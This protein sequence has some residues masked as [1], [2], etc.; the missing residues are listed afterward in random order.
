[1]RVTRGREERGE[2]EEGGER[3]EFPGLL[4]GEMRRADGDTNSHALN[5]PAINTST[6]TTST[7]NLRKPFHIPF[8]PIPGRGAGPKKM[9]KWEAWDA[10]HSVRKYAEE[11]W[12]Q[13]YWCVG[14]VEFHVQDKESKVLALG[15]IGWRYS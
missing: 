9:T 6:T 8:I 3:E 4:S 11:H 15:G 1:M 7:N 10:I 2:R 13:R 5:N 14:P 12:R